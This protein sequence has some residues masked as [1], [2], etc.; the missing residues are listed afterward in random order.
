MARDSSAAPT[1]RD[2]RL[3]TAYARSQDE[4]ALRQL[5]MRWAPLARALASRYR[6]AR[7]PVDDLVQV[8]NLGLVKAIQGFEPDRGVPFTAFAVPTILGELRRHFRDRVWNLRLPRS[9]QE[10]TMAVEKA[11]DSLTEALGRAPSTEEIAAA[12]E[13]STEE[14]EEALVAREARWTTSMDAPV[15]S[16]DDGAAASPHDL[17]G[18]EDS[19][20]DRVEADFACADAELSD[21]ERQTI[22]LRFGAQ[23]TQT[24]IGE[25]LGISQMQVSRLSRRGLTR[26]L[27]AVR[28]EDPTAVG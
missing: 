21:E 23:M 17:I 6:G 9:L 13:L 15:R 8:A 26:L 2:L 12:A 22:E 27:A 4:D 19:G 28:G 14:V 18:Q 7:E 25:R 1:D 5:V 10:S 16:D 11:K 20:Y 3:L 24:E